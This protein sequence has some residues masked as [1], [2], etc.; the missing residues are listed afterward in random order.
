M[1][2]RTAARRRRQAVSGY[3][4]LARIGH[5]GNNRPIFHKRSTDK[6]A[7]HEVQLRERMKAMAARRS[8]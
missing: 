8:K 6:Q 3:R 5:G 1:S 4:H 2:A 7:R